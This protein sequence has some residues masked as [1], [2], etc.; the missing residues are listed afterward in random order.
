M[1]IRSA[2]C[3]WLG[4]VQASNSVSEVDTVYA[5]CGCTPLGKMSQVSQPYVAGNTRVWTTFTYDGLGRTVKQTAPDNSVTQYSY[6]GN[7]L[8][9]TH[10]AGNAKTLTMDTFGNITSVQE[11]DSQLGS[12][13]TSYTY[14]VLNH[15]TKVVVSQT[16]LASV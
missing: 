4:T 12:V 15:L 7:T 5:P 6:S 13:T 11:T 2:S 1:P 14:D 10:P 16:A 9:I 3:T 8:T